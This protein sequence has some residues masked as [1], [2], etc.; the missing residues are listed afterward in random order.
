MCKDFQRDS[1]SDP[2]NKLM[3]GRGGGRG[4]V[5]VGSGRDRLWSRYIGMGK[6]WLSS[7]RPGCSTSKGEH[8]R[9]LK[10]LESI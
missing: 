3:E 7:G 5:D 6:A 9:G 4:M 8:A 10:W 1:S 2:G